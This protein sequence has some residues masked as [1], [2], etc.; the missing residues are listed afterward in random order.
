MDD[1]IGFRNM[2]LGKLSRK[3]RKAKKKNKKAMQE[4]SPEDTEETLNQIEGDNSLEAADFRWKSKMNQLSP[5]EMVRQIALFLLCWGE[6]NQVRFT[7]ECL[8]FIYKCAS[9]YLD[10]AQ[11]QQRPDPLP[12][13][14]F[15]NRV[16]TPLYRFIRSQVYEIVDG[17]YVKSE[18]II[19]KLL[20]MMMSINYSG[21]QK[22]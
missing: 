16:I 5:F 9:D 1:E 4:A 21:I 17:R 19:T 20:G 14:D 8:C 6:A 12:E 13:G 10:S 18:K 15:L 22:V 11:C 3:A 2:K 7:P